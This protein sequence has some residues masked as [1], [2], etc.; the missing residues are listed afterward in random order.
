MGFA[1]LILA[2]S[3]WRFERGLNLAVFQVDKHW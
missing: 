3:I 1:K 2:Q